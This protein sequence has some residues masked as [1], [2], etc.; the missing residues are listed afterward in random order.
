MTLIEG[1]GC[2]FILFGLFF[3]FLGVVGI[4]RF[5]DTYTRLHASGKTGTLGIFFLCL[6]A[7][8]L[9]PSSA[10]KSI[11]LGAFIIFS[12][13]VA[14]HAIALAVYRSEQRQQAKMDNQPVSTGD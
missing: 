14:S 12:G 13:P 4:L 6:G 11:I 9:L 10:F 5:P 1:I 3:S 8:F 2:T 7:A